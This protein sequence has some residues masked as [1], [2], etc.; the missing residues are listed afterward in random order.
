MGWA[1]AIKRPCPEKL[2]NAA[3]NTERIFYEV[4]LKGKS[5]EYRAG[6]TWILNLVMLE[7]YSRPLSFK[8]LPDKMGGLI[9]IDCIAV[10]IEMM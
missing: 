7:N 1:M 9:S 4:S 8:F 5:S 10:N 2:T 3:N 6:K